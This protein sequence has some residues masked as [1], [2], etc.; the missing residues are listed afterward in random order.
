MIGAVTHAIQPEPTAANATQL[1]PAAK[2]VAPSQKP[3]QSQPHTSIPT[4]T[5]QISNAART[6]QQEMLE[7]PAQTAKEASSGDRQ[8]Q[9]LLAREAAAKAE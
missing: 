1:N 7:T 4:D 8:A 3:T 5:V 6:A 9:R 2:S